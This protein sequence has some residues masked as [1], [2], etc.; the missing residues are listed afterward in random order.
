MYK[1]DWDMICPLKDDALTHQNQQQETLL[2]IKHIQSLLTL[3]TVIW[4]MYY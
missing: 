1:G 4:G 2:Y 3:L